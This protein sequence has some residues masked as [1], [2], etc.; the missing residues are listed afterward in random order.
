MKSIFRSPSLLLEDKLRNLFEYWQ[1]SSP[2]IF[3]RYTLLPI[4]ALTFTV[5]FLSGGL[6]TESIPK[7]LFTSPLSTV[8]VM[9]NFPLGASVLPKNTP[10]AK[11]QFEP[12]GWW[13]EPA[14]VVGY[15]SVTYKQEV[16][17]LCKVRTHQGQG[18]VLSVNPSWVELAQ[19]QSVER[20]RS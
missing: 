15:E 13:H 18:Y 10:Q 20:K 19:R 14:I 3:R 1:S 16:I 9:K 17:M 12:V 2:P 11:D 8:R 6:W 7:T 4:L 5:G